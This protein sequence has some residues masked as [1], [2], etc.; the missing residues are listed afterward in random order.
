MEAMA[1]HRSHSIAF[2]RQ[3]AQ[4][5]LSGETLRGLAV[6]HDLSRN[7]IR[8]WVAKHEA[9]AF[10]E[11]AQAADLLQEDEGRFA[12]LEGVGGGQALEIE[13]LKGGLGQRPRPK[14]A[15]TS[16]VAGP[17]R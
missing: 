9:G 4:E 1:R 7:L 10:D 8:I 15:P 11:D 13:F 17:P 12:A 14:G 16:V 6:R 5:H 3:V 2:K